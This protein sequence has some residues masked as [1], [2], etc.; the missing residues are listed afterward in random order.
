ML[1][2]KCKYATGF[3]VKNVSNSFFFFSIRY[4]ITEIQGV[5]EN[6]KFLILAPYSENSTKSFL[7]PILIEA[8]LFY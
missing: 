4:T 2:K 7:I 3:Y 8:S 5:P 1:H 6:A